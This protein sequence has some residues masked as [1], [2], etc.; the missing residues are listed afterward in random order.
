MD[1]MHILTKTITMERPYS[2]LMNSF[3][4]AGAVLK[5]AVV[6]KGF[7]QKTLLQG[8][9]DPELWCLII[10]A[11]LITTTASAAEIKKCQPLIIECAYDITVECG[12]MLDP[13]YTGG[14]IIN[15]DPDCPVLT[16]IG[17]VDYTTGNCP[18]VIKRVWTAT[19]DE[20][21]TETCVQFITVLDTMAPVFTIYPQDTTVTCENVPDPENVEAVDNCKDF[22][23]VTLNE[24]TI[25]G[26]CGTQFTLIRTW[27]TYDDC[28]NVA[29][30]SQMINV[31]DTV[32]PV[33]FGVPA[34]IT[35]NC[36][37]VP[38]P[39]PNVW[40]EDNC[41]SYQTVYPADVI[42]PGNCPNSYVIERTWW[43]QDGCGNISW[44]TQI[45]TLIDTTA[46]V[47]SEMPASFYAECDDIPVAPLV[48]ALDDCNDEVAVIYNETNIS[49]DCVNSYTLERT[50]SA[51]D[52]CGNNVTHTQI[53]TVSDTVAPQIFLIGDSDDQ[54]ILC[55]DPIPAEP[56]AMVIDNCDGN[57]AVQI[58]DTTIAGGCAQE[59]TILRE[60]TATDVCG[61][62]TTI[63]QTI[64]IVD[65]I[66]P[67]FSYVPADL[68]LDCGA[69]IPFDPAEAS[70][71]CDNNISIMYED[72]IISGSCAGEQTIFRTWIAMDECG[73]TNQATQTI[74]TIDTLGP[75]FD[76]VIMDTIVG[77]DHIP[78][79]PE[80]TATDACQGFVIAD[81]DGEI[82]V[83]GGCANA[84]ILIRSWT[85]M[86]DCGNSTTQI[87]TLFV[88]DTMP[89]ILSGIP[90]DTIVSCDDIPDPALVQAVDN[91]DQNLSM[92]YNQSKQGGNCDGE[93]TLV[94]TWTAADGCDNSSFAQQ[95]ITVIDTVAPTFDC[96]PQDITVDCNS[97][98]DPAICNATDNCDMDPIV[99]F[100]QDSTG[101][102]C[103]GVYTITRTF[104]AVDHC[105][106]STTIVQVIT[107]DNG[108]GTPN[109][110][111]DFEQNDILLT[112]FPNPFSEETMIR[113]ILPE[114]SDALLEVF[115]MRGRIVEVLYDGHTAANV[116]V[117]SEFR[118]QQHSSGS[119]IYRLRANDRILHGRLVVTR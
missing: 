24:T 32:A 76:D 46:P 22:L 19:N 104:T 78:D 91:C 84:Y 28:Q 41:K 40:A 89:P 73:N 42:F 92:F 36:D 27:S 66:A 8:L 81:Y 88:I 1:Q 108:P 39:D 6:S 30:H 23:I 98:P 25:A 59:W 33:I 58:S 102:G 11:F 61:N 67:Q 94:R 70:D 95:W 10:I 15:K 37:N 111:E 93:Y 85:A 80:C 2:R 12:D 21:H 31:I 50:W 82:V 119:Y 54:V 38:E 4:I 105:G 96:D 56:V 20:G 116:P 110:I 13:S 48:I 113:F 34:D 55:S 68:T 17:W 109:G 86:D 87:Q 71:E 77:C 118:P 3:S 63:T 47:L 7:R 106:N 45:I 35:V 97:I 52:E 112:A 62:T 100:S 29:T 18:K 114:A 9:L 14:P 5:N 60:W 53:I 115:D 49:G 75:V 26:E 44:A 101:S 69:V 79:V 57:V 72:T 74:T 90:A 99:T 103:I 43:S 16:F 64:N 51:T 65:T 117:D 107:V 83:P